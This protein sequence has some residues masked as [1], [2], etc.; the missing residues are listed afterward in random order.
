[1]RWLRG[2]RFSLLPSLAR[3]IQC[4]TLVCRWC[5][6][7][8]LPAFERDSPA[9][10]SGKYNHLSPISLPLNQMECTFSATRIEREGIPLL[11]MLHSI[12]FSGGAG[13]CASKASTGA[14]DMSYTKETRA[15]ATRVHIGSRAREDRSQGSRGRQAALALCSRVLRSYAVRYCS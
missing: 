3:D 12:T 4:S 8:A 15:S 1:M 11:K 2:S 7:C 5:P 6:W 9:G 14:K 13:H 10:W